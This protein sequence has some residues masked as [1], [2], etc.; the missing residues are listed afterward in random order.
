MRD[1]VL[2]RWH[3]QEYG[4]TANE[5]I[6]AK[7]AI[8]FV[9][10]HFAWINGE[11]FC[12]DRCPTTPSCH[13]LPCKHTHIPPNSLAQSSLECE[14]FVLI[15]FEVGRF[16]NYYYTTAPAYIKPFGIPF[17][18]WTKLCTCAMAI[19][20]QVPMGAVVLPNSNVSFSKELQSSNATQCS[21]V[22]DLCVAKQRR[23]H[24][25]GRNELNENTIDA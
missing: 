10:T 14:N 6:V 12:P 22:H 13:F 9:C 4:I 17:T 3:A 18:Q 8:N 11:R 19:M 23:L 25:T 5:Y 15:K 16:C 20:A 2:T 1:P 24:R 21:S 7:C